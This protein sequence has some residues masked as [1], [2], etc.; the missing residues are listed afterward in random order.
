MNA[1]EQAQ[2]VTFALGR[3]HF[4]SDVRSVERVLRHQAPRPIPNVP[5]WVTGVIDYAGRVVPV[6]DVRARFGLPPHELAGSERV[7]V[8]DVAGEWIAA[9]VDQVIDVTVLRDGELEAPPP[10]FRG[11]AGEYLQGMIRRQGRLIVVLDA[12]RLLSSTEQLQLHAALDE[13]AP[14]PVAAGV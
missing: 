13:G 4:A 8:F 5:A 6:V 9:V 3:D 11:L 2:I 10:L 14:A 1:E 12:G 7:I